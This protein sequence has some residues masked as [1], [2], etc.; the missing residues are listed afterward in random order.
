MGR[1]TFLFGV[2]VGEG[3]FGASWCG[4]KVGSCWARGEGWEWLI[5]VLEF[6]IGAM[7]MVIVLFVACYVFKIGLMCGFRAD[8]E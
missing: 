1:K 3:G 6:A 2:G 4:E 7:L 8:L 5:M